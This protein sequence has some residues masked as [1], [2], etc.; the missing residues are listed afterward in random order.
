[1][2]RNS[3]IYLYSETKYQY[4]KVNDYDLYLLG[5]PLYLNISDKNSIDWKEDLIDNLNKRPAHSDDILNGILKKTTGLFSLILKSE[6]EVIIASDIIRSFPLFYG[7]INGEM[8]VT[9]SLEQFQNENGR[10]DLDFERLEEFISMGMVI[11]N[12]TIYKNVNGLQSAEVVVLNS[13]NQY[14]TRYFKFVTTD[15]VSGLKNISA[16]GRALDNL[17]EFVFTRLVQVTPNVRN[18]I[19]PLSGGHD[20]RLIVNYLYRLG[21][22][23]VICFS[24]GAPGNDQSQISKSVARQLGYNWHFVEY[25]DE[26]WKMLQDK[27]IFDNYVFKSFNGVSTPH[28]Q[29]FL[30]IYE[31][32]SKGIIQKGDIIIPGHT[33]VRENVFNSTTEKL[34]KKI[35]ALNYVFDRCLRLALCKS[36]TAVIFNKLEKIYDESAVN[37]EDFYAYFDWQ[38]RRS[39][40][41]TN[42]I[43]TYD[44][45]GIESRQPM[46]DKEIAGFWLQVP[47]EMREGRSLLYFAEKSG[48]IVEE[49]LSI[50]YA[51]NSRTVKRLSAKDIIRFIVPDYIITALLKITGY[52]TR[53]NERLNMIYSLKAGSVRQ[54]LD[55]VEEFPDSILSS[56]KGDLNRRTYQ[57]DPNIL[58][59]LYAIRLQLNSQY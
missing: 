46:W 59:S 16:Y 52:K 45:F 14:M 25:T 47:F 54:L 51:S 41:I 53:L 20:S 3:A 50:P 15:L 7:Y 27:G 42:S 58:T 38:E 31:L 32:T 37:P 39:K 22:K 43:R 26:K 6:T 29:D 23:N 2:I 33:A 9:D 1:M 34:D 18:W 11:G 28:I 57:M 8:F 40:F 35:E 56:L 49:L 10:F 21:I 48:V 12:G 30:A 36:K 55:P 5:N 44:F 24:Y 4:I 13:E 17:L 19:I